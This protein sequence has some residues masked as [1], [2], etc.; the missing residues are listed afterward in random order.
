MFRIAFIKIILLFQGTKFIKAL[1][2]S[3]LWIPTNFF[4]TSVTLSYV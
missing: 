2:L 1:F 4:F 3:M